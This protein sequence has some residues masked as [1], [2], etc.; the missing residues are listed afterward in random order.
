MCVRILELTRNELYLDFRYLDMALSTLIFTPRE[1]L[2]SFATDGISLYFSPEQILRVFK[3]NPLFLDRAY[4]H[5][6]L[7]C[8]FRH[9]WMRGRREP[10]LWNLATDIA[11]EHTIDSFDKKTTKRALSLTRSRY[12]SHL[13]EKKIP[14]TAAAIYR[15]LL[16][17]TDMEEQ[18]ALQM[19][20]YT[21]DHRFW[22]TDPSQSP[23]AASAGQSWEKIG[24]R[25]TKEMEMRGEQDASGLSSVTSQIEKGKSRRS[26]REF[27]RKFTVLKE[28][29]HCD[30]DSFD[31]TYYTYGLQL[32]KNMPLIEPLETRE[33][34]KIAE[35]VI[36]IDTSFSTDGPLVKRF[37]QETFQ[38]ITQR[39]SFFQK[40]HIH[41]IQCDNQVHSD[42]V[43]TSAQDID[44]LLDSFSL[45]GGGGTD[46]HPAFAYVE[47]LLS[48]GMFQNLKGLLYFTDGKGIYPSKCPSY[49][50]AFLFMD[51]DEDSRPPVPAWAMSMKLSQEDFDL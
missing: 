23:S 25:A 24:R 10:V 47:E 36:V 3:N 33:I 34:M 43:I 29:L 42:T 20:F 21:D 45:T 49:D 8:I 28:E 4:L 44:R 7:H 41:I 26:Y 27:L 15:D 6:V 11:V 14:V 17:V 19:E 39:D 22:P 46:F 31:L 30:D 40:S 37:L 5:S 48:Q 38:I 50:T 16:S 18:M 1:E 2:K 12:Y 13:E 9:L 35:F 51:G 32:Y